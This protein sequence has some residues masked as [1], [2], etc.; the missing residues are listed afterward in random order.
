MHKPVLVQDENSEGADPT[1]S[2]NPSIGQY[3]RIDRGDMMKNERE[4]SAT[5]TT[6]MAK[7]ECAERD[8]R[9]ERE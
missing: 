8:G 7:D 3:P 6:L 2:R 5:I 9:R 1:T 4:Q